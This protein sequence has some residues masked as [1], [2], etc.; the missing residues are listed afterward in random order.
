MPD[1]MVWVICTDYGTEG[2]SAPFYWFDSEADAMAAKAAIDNLSYGA[3][4]VK[5]VKAA[6]WK[7]VHQT[8]DEIE[9]A[10]EPT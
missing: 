4:S 5:I 10:G 6:P 2:L 8:S 3:C 1:G 9:A 7:L